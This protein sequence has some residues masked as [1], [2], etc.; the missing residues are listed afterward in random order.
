MTEDGAIVSNLPNV[1]LIAANGARIAGWRRRHLLLPP[2]RIKARAD[3]NK[4]AGNLDLHIWTSD[5]GPAHGDTSL[6]GLPEARGAAGSSLRT[7]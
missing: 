1:G 4:T 6:G 2:R 5:P 3:A 7:S